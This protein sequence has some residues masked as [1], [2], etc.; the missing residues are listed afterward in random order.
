MAERSL[1]PQ[2]SHSSE[3]ELSLSPEIL[4]FSQSG[5]DSDTMS[6]E[7]AAPLLNPVQDPLVGLDLDRLLVE[8]LGEWGW[9][10]RWVYL[11]VCLPAALTAAITLAS[12]F[13]AFSPA[14]RCLVPTCDSPDRPRYDDATAFGFANFTEP[15]GS[16]GCRVFLPRDNSSHCSA[17]SFSN[18]STDCPAGLLWDTQD[19]RTTLATEF[20]LTCGREWELPASQSVFFAGVLVGAALF[21][22]LAD[23]LGRRPVFLACLLQTLVCG[24]AAAL[25]PAFPVFMVAQFFTAMGQVGLFQTVFVLGVECVGPGYRVLCGVVIE[26]FFVLGEAMLAGFAALLRDWRHLQL[27]ATLPGLAFLSYYWLLPESLRW[28]LLTG[29]YSRARAQLARLARGNGVELPGPAELS[30]YTKQEEEEEEVEGEGLLDIARRPALLGRLLNVFFNWFVI[31]MIYYGLSLNSTSLAGDLFTNFLLVSLCELPGYAG[32]YL[33]MSLLGRRTTLAASLLTGGLGCLVS[34][35]T[36]SYISTSAFLLG[37]FG[38]TAAFGTTYLY[39]SELFPTRVR[40]VCVGLSSMTGRLGGILCPYVA[41]L[42]T[43][44]GLA[45]SPMAV[46]AAA[47]TLSGLLTLALPETRGRQLPRTMMEAEQLGRRETQT[48]N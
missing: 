11:L 24:T 33:G 10:Q 41:R 25:A 45:W 23:L 8:R 15:L 39:T 18:T 38:A 29:R 21:G 31:T 13:T 36:Q 30:T 12:V 35:L 4:H 6:E 42:G 1:D 32:A 14:H 46:F 2:L 27:A 26:F 34:S 20:S 22:W 5:S 48:Q 28:L 44:T 7:E 19:M 16:R 9:Y 3:R 17:T 43:L 40:N 47:A 37:K